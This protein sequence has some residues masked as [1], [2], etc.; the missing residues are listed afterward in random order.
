MTISLFVVYL[1]TLII[2]LALLFYVSFLLGWYHCK[3]TYDDAIFNLQKLE[4]EKKCQEL[5]GGKQ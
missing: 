4:R 1:I 5:S 3:S 2:I